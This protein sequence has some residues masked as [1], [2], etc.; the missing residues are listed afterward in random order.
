MSDSSSSLSCERQAAAAA[1][2]RRSDSERGKRQA[3]PQSLPSAPSAGAPSGGPPQQQVLAISMHS[4]QS[5][6]GRLLPLP[7]GMV[8]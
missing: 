8:C 6:F 7:G 1:A 5:S 4:T 2:A 3:L